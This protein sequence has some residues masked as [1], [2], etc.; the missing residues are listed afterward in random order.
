MATPKTKIENVE[1]VEAVP[2]IIPVKPT[3]AA[4]LAL[5]TGFI[6][7]HAESTVNEVIDFEGGSIV[8]STF[9]DHASFAA[10]LYAVTEASGELR[11][12]V[13]SRSLAAAHKISQ[14]R[15]GILA[16]DSGE[17]FEKIGLSAIQE[18]DGVKIH[19]PIDLT[20]VKSFFCNTNPEYLVTFLSNAHI[21][22]NYAA[23]PHVPTLSELSDKHPKLTELQVEGVKINVKAKNLAHVTF[24]NAD[25]LD[26]FFVKASHLQATDT[27]RLASQNL[28][29]REAGTAEDF[30]TMNRQMFA[31]FSKGDLSGWDIYA[32]LN[33]V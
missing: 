10:S 16:F 22:M 15:Y 20:F 13:A 28:Y 29:V 1:A 31:K 4:A 14:Y 23:L 25:A 24:T 27:V 8:L 12:A 32:V 5:L 18:K 17:R 26:S 30:G 2:A 3:L 7:T 9:S 33:L 21:N 19:T 11:K 6:N